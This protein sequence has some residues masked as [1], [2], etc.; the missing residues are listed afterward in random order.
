MVEKTNFDDNE[1]ELSHLES[2]SEQFMDIISKLDTIEKEQKDELGKVRTGKDIQIDNDEMKDLKTG[3]IYDVPVREIMDEIYDVYLK[4]LPETL[5]E[6]LQKAQEVKETMYQKY[7]S[8]IARIRAE[9]ED[10]MEFQE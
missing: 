10:E 7:I 4:T 1:D 9:Q 2:Q 5:P 6:T 8:R 3:N